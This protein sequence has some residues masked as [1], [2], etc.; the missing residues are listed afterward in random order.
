MVVLARRQATPLLIVVLCLLSVTVF[1]RVALLHQSLVP[2]D[3]LYE[4]DPLWSRPA[5]SPAVTSHNYLEYDIV[6]QFYPWAVMYATA[7]HHG[8]L[9]LWN[10]YSFAGTPFLAALQ[11]AVLYPIDLALGWL[12]QP[13]DILGVRAIVQLAL[14][15][16]GMFLFA[17]RLT[18]SRAA[19]LVAALAFG[20][21]LPCFVWI[22]DTLSVAT[23]WLPWML[24]AVEGT[25]TACRRLPWMLGLAGAFAME[26]LSGQGEVAAHAALL[27]VAYAMFRLAILWRRERDL[28]A[29][30]RLIL[31]LIVGFALGASLAAAQLAPTVEQLSRSSAAFD[32][33]YGA[34]AAPVGIL[35]QSLNWG[36][37]V[38]GVIPDFY[39]NPT[40][41]LS[42]LP[43]SQNY[44]ESALYVGTVPL[45]LALF[46]IL[47]V[48][49]AHIRFFALAAFVA[50]GIA[51]RFP[52]IG[53][54]N[55]APILR[56]TINGRLHVEYAFAISVLAGYGLDMIGLGGIS[57]KT[58]RFMLRWGVTLATLGAMAI[59]T[60]SRSQAG[61]AQLLSPVVIAS[62]TPALW[63]ALFAALVAHYASKKM[64]IDTFKLFVVSLVAIDLLSLT[65]NFHTTTPRPQTLAVPPAV[66]FV[67]RDHSLYRVVGLG[68]SLIP[69][70]SSNVSLQ[71]IRGYDPAYGA[72]YEQYF[73]HN[74]GASGPAP[75]V[76]W[77]KPASPA[78]RS[79]DLLNV[80]YIFASCGSLHDAHVYPLVYQGVGCVYRNKSVIPRAFI[81]HR[82]SLASGTRATAL[83]GDGVVN[84]RRVAMID[85]TTISKAKDWELSLRS[86]LSADSVTIERYDL[87]RVDL[88]AR[89][90]QR[91]VLVLSDTY[92][93]GWHAYVDGRPTS[94]ARVNATFRAVLFGPGGHR[95]SFVYLPDSFAYGSAMSV[96]SIII[97]LSLLVVAAVRPLLK[98]RRQSSND[99][100]ISRPPLHI[101]DD[102]ALSARHI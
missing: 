80:A 47:R 30:V 10:P 97:W 73:A 61:H 41:R 49:D 100:A 40:W 78:A 56:V 82:T 34:H 21:G 87:N 20:L 53:M 9:P 3:I 39:G 76:N 89:S 75:V 45:F 94:I 57:R 86:G 26:L 50:L 1:W 84:P 90:V 36:T 19:A 81:V 28:A 101:P 70:V 54:L 64:S 6:T 31:I 7:L 46:A 69:D 74:F 22:P 59:I 35:G 33:E 24:L 17:R 95:V 88:V 77:L 79:L 15:L 25:L 4:N 14:A 5:S 48:R 44:F 51:L 13:L 63:F 55:D 32:R 91:G 2:V 102:P 83:L 27:C 98:R 67:Q 65:I 62:A 58:K 72:A 43:L 18:L 42:L 38:V 11:P 71:D 52:L 60:L 93:P 23:T 16:V 8:I 96:T 37:L 99:V 12:A 66:R 68:E 29:I 92:A 85:P